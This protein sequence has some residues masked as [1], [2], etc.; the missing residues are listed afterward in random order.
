MPL[1]TGWRKLEDIVVT[2]DALGVAATCS[3][4]KPLHL[5]YCR[6]LVLKGGYFSFQTKFGRS[7]CSGPIDVSLP[8]V[9]FLPYAFRDPDTDIYLERANNIPKEAMNC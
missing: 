1:N 8:L 3:V 2:E 9:D 4:R 7:L 5:A 6:K